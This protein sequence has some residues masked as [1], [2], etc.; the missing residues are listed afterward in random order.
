MLI[1]ILY[2]LPEIGVLRLP[3]PEHLRSRGVFCHIER[4]IHQ[5]DIHAAAA[6][7]RPAPRLESL[8][9]CHYLFARHQQHHPVPSLR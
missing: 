5:Y 4:S 6:I 1:E 9:R 7:P 2:F 8:A 3:S